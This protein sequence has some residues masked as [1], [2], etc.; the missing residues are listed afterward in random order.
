MLTYTLLKAA[1]PALSTTAIVAICTVG[2]AAVGALVLVA[3]AVFG[4]AKELNA[5]RLE[6]AALRLEMTQQRGDDRREVLELIDKR[7]GQHRAEC[8]AR[9]NTGVRDMPIRSP[10][11]T[12][13]G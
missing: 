2:T 6:I 9:E 8:S 7:L 12:T 11:P 4:W 13:G 10:A 5:L 1:D 3:R